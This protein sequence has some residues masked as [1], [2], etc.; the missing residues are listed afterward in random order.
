MTKAQIIKQLNK[1]KFKK[2]LWKSK[3]NI[4]IIQ[5]L[6][7]KNLNFKNFK[8]MKIRNVGMAAIRNKIHWSWS[9]KIT[10][11]ETKIM[12]N[13]NMNNKKQKHK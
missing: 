1:L 11:T 2:K 12:L 10:K 13:R 3:W 4:K 9:T 5:K 8:V 7:E 6:N